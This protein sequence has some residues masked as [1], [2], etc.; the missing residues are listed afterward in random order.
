MTSSTSRSSRYIG[1]VDEENE[2]K[3]SHCHSSSRRD[4][5]ASKK[6]SS[7]S[8]TIRIGDAVLR[9]TPSMERMFGNANT[10]DVIYEEPELIRVSPRS[11]SARIVRDGLHTNDNA[12]DQHPTPLRRHGKN[13]GFSE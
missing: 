2:E 13:I 3:E 6:R 11:P 4:S 8:G 7:I 5:I 1:I 10:D 12:P 9:P